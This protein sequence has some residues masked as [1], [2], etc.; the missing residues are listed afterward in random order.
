MLVFAD[1][2]LTNRTRGRHKDYEAESKETMNI[3]EGIVADE[4]PKTIIFLGDIIGYSDTV[5][6]HGDFFTRVLGFFMNLNRMTEGRVF[7]VKGNH[8]IAPTTDF[9]TL[10]GVGLLKNPQYLDS[11][12]VRYHFVNYGDEKEPIQLAVRKDIN[13]ENQIA[14]I[15]FGHNDFAIDNQTTWYQTE[16]PL[17]VSTLTN[18]SGVRMIVSGHIHMTSEDLIETEIDGNRVDVY[19]PGSICR[20][21]SNDHHEVCSYL[22]FDYSGDSD[23]VSVEIEELSLRPLSDILEEKPEDEQTAEEIEESVNK[24]SIKDVVNMLSQRRLRKT[25]I[26]DQIESLPE[27]LFS[28]RGKKYTKKVITEQKNRA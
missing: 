24:E 2:H 7:T 9:D 20:V 25:D 4:K 14:N 10:T 22:C 13:G 12:N 11:D 17:Y 27:A 19:Y 26:F 3:I 21:A 1:L 16:D 8:D 23:R 28:E 15:V 5:L 18:L 6:K